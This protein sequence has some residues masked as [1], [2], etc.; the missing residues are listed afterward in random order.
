MASDYW[1]RWHTLRAS[2]RRFVGGSA[3][4]GAGVAGL[5]LVGCGDDDDD[6]DDG[7]ATTTATGTG[8]AATS[9]GTT[10]AQPKTG[11]TLRVHMG[12][13]PRSLD[14]HFDTFPFNTAITDNTNERLLKWATDF[15][16]IETE[17]ADAM[18]EQA[19]PLTFTFKIKSGINFHDVAP[20]NGRAFT[21]EDVKY[22]IER[23]ST[24]EAGKFQHAYFFLN[25]LESIET[26]D[27]STVVF[28]TKAPYAP[29]L[30]Y[31]A[32]PWT[33]MIAREAVEEFG[34]LTEHAVGTGPFMFKE[35][36]KDVKIDIVKNP[37]Y[38]Q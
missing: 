7:G 9:T 20:V 28:K 15:S 24:D 30:S 22:S 36:Q 12:G 5:A 8:T 11:G 23:Q 3:L 1:S 6:D 4:A 21:A 2:R 32:S 19:D 38:W 25:K 16:A 14:P 35:W 34:D 37:N 27:E 17:L 13:S 29:F 33:L 26:P 10:A 31:M 18:P